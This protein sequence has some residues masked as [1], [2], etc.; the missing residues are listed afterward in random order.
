[1]QE[2]LY[3]QD[4]FDGVHA[5]F[6]ADC[7]A[8]YEQYL[9][10]SEKLQNF[11][12]VLEKIREIKPQGKFLDIGC[13]TGVFLDMAKKDGYDVVGVDVS[14]F[15]CEYAQ[16]HF[17]IPTFCGKIEDLPL[18]EKSFDVITMWDVLEHVPDPNAFLKNVWKLLKDDGILFLLTI[19]DASLMGWI[20]NGMYRL[21]LKQVNYF[22]KVIHPIHH[23]FHF[24]ENHLLQ[25]LGNNGFSVVWKEKREMPVSN[26]EGGPVLKTMARVLYLFSRATNTEHEI[27]VLGRKT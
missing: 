17:G 21:S 5:H 9:G 16:E 14:A 3:S 4:Y 26:I 18:K 25:Y 8:G 15:A 7:R 10:S 23:N 11:R 1:M 6:F 20:A 19:N 27:L 2:D 24:A 13:A 22:T 12:H